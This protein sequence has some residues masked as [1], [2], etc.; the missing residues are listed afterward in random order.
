MASPPGLYQDERTN[1]KNS[2]SFP[3]GSFYI[4]A[5]EF[6]CWSSFHCYTIEET[7]KVF[8]SICQDGL[9]GNFDKIK[10]FPFIIRVLRGWTDRRSLSPEVRRGVL[11][12]GE[13]AL[14]HEGIYLEV[15]HIV[16]ISLGGSDDRSNLQCLCRKCNR[17]KGPHS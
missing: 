3:H 6:L 15:D 10:K 9:K 11:S 12:V 7:G 2:P 16:P 17:S 4:D 5:S 13:C 14:C 1:V 8:H